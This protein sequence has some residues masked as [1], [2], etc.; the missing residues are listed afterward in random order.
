MNYILPI[1]VMPEMNNQTEYPIFNAL[2]IPQDGQRVRI[3][4]IKIRE[5]EQM[6]YNKESK[7]W[8]VKMDTLPTVNPKTGEVSIKTGP[9]KGFVVDFYIKDDPECGVRSLKINSK[10]GVRYMEKYVAERKAPIEKYIPDEDL[11]LEKVDNGPGMYPSVL[12][13]GA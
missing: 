4:V 3:G 5:V 9:A 6:T 8:S 10:A 2:D 11:V 7:T 13:I 12:P 1:T